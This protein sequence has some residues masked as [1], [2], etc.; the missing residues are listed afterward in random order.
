MSNPAKHENACRDEAHDLP[1]VAT[2]QCES[3]NGSK[4][5]HH[6]RF[7]AGSPEC[8]DSPE[9]NKSYDER[10][11]EKRFPAPPYHESKSDWSYDKSGTVNN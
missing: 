3:E 8:A 4:T 9:G 2:L 7:R 10:Q 6:E 5:N 11:P 1:Q